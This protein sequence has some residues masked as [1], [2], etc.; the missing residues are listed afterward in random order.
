MVE[1]KRKFSQSVGFTESHLNG[2]EKLIKKENGSIS[3]HT[4]AALDMYLKAKG[5]IE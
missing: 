1:K 5:I 4:R 2:L 3:S